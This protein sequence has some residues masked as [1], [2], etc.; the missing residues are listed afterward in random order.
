MSG[1]LSVALGEARVPLAAFALCLARLLGLLQLLPLSTRLGLTGLHR[2]GVAAGLTLPLLPMVIPQLQGADLSGAHLV[3]LTG[4]EAFVGFGLGILF[5]LPFWTVEAAGELID[6]QRGS[7]GATLPD[8]AGEGENGITATL[9]VLTLVTVFLLS[10][11]MR[12]L[13]DGVVDSYRLWPPTT[14]VPPL[15]PGDGL[16][17]LTMLDG[18][19]GAGLLLAAP[20]LIAMLLAELSLAL[21]SRFAPQ[22]NVFDLAMSVKGLVYVIGLPLY[23]VFLIGYMREELAPLTRFEDTLRRLI[24]G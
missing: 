13:F 14:I 20:L 21:V 7:R 11:G 6:Q 17:M 16:T 1:L 12:W 18:I 23:S 22:L 9:L 8:P 15:R 2:A 3:L 4:K 5:A 19:L 10:G 24:G